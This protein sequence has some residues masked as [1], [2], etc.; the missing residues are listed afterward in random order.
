MKPVRLICIENNST[1]YPHELFTAA[2][3]APESTQPASSRAATVAL[4]NCYAE[5]GG[6]GILW[7]SLTTTAAWSKCVRK[8][9]VIFPASSRIEHV[10]ARSKIK[11]QFAQ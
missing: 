8:A 5:A 9:Q 11:H 7:I 6:T 10:Q 3:H 2:L 4:G 1:H